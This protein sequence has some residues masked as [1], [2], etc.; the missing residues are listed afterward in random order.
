MSRHT[1]NRRDWAFRSGGFTMVELLV[2]I[3][4]IGML[5]AM[6]LGAVHISREA[7]RE[8]KT[9]ATIREIDGALEDALT[10]VLDDE[11][12]LSEMGR[13]SRH[14]VDERYLWADVADSYERVLEG[15]C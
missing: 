9:K 15:L 14:V 12:R 5:A 10:E 8:A 7:A 2:T 1:A 13:E 11:T 3:G 4:I 6:M